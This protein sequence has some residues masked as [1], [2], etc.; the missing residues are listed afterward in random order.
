MYFVT[1]PPSLGSILTPYLC[2][3]INYSPADVCPSVC[4]C[5]FTGDL[6]SPQY[7]H[8]WERKPAVQKKTSAEICCVVFSAL[9]YIIQSGSERN[10]HY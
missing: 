6:T 3:Q 10:E 7:E 9:E 5:V 1:Y 4:I 8:N 2:H